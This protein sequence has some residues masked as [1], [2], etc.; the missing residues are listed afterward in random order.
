MAN[1]EDGIQSQRIG[2]GNQQLVIITQLLQM[3]VNMRHI[4]EMFLW[5]S[6]IIGQRLNVDVLQFWAY[7]AHV[8][9]QYSA[10]LRA[11]AS[12]NT[13]FPLHVV[14]NAQVAE[15]VR[16]IL[17]ERSGVNPQ[18][19]ASVFSS[20]QADL[21][22]RYNLH[23]WACFFLGSGELLPPLM[24]SDPTHGAIPTPLSMVVSL[25]TQQ[26]PHPH[27]MSTIKRIMEHAL[28]IAKNRGLISNVGN[29]VS[30]NIANNRAQPRQLT[31]NELI[32]HWVQDVEA[33]QADNPFADGVVISDK[34]A[35]QLY[36]A[37]DGKK[38]IAE[39]GDSTRM[40]QQELSSALRFLLKQKHIRL[41]EPNGKVV[42]SSQF[43]V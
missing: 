19:V 38:S 7:Q 12:Q 35:R 31:F 26:T 41:H 29:P 13:L 23:Y 37:I 28:S 20:R 10:E 32:P 16:D 33:M 25:F 8:T 27:L 5:L 39:L 3:S 11:T 22:S 2:G 30:S 18:P 14:N 34:Q 9:G 6:H 24:S 1:N 15:I 40:D 17:T 36:F 42:D 21:L 43:F 4:D